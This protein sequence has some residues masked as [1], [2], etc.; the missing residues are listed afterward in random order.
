MHRSDIAP[1][2]QNV[3]ALGELFSQQAVEAVPGVVELLVSAGDF[4][5]TH[6][7]IDHRQP[8]RRDRRARQLAELDLAQHIALVALHPAGVELHL[9][10]PVGALFDH[11]LPL[12]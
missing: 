6:F 3:A 9:D 2:E 11:A 5:G 1:A 8:D 7:G 4:E 12:V 10:A